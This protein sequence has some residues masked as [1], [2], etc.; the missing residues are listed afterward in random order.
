MKVE[1]PD[2]NL[3]GC[4]FGAL[5]GNLS[6]IS[7]NPASGAVFE[8]SRFGVSLI[9]NNNSTESIYNNQNSLSSG[10]SNYQAGLI[11]VFKKLWKWKISN[12]FSVELEFSFCYN[13]NGEIKNIRRSQN[14]VDNFFLNNFEKQN[15]TILV[16]VLMKL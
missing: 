10:N 8:L 6:V 9:V 11:Y 15:V 3:G 14:S 4:A 7:N 1:I 5:G 2:M 12:K 13:F 16:L